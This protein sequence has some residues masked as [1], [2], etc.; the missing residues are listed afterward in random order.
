MQQKEIHCTGTEST[1]SQLDHGAI[2]EHLSGR[3]GQVDG[4]LRLGHEH[5]IPRRIPLIVQGQMVDAHKD[6]AQADTIGLVVVVD[7][8]ADAVH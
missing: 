1:Q 6:G 8:G 7:E 4:L 3:I 5:Q 2:V